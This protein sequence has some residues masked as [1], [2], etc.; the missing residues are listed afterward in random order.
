MTYETIGNITNYDHKEIVVKSEGLIK[1]PNLIMKLYSMLPKDG[2]INIDSA[3]LFVKNKIDE[4]DIKP[5]M[6]G[7][8]FTI[9]SPSILNAS[10]WGAEF[11]ILAKNEVYLF[12]KND[13][14]DAVKLDLNKEGAYCAF[15]SIIFAYEGN[16]WINYLK[17]QKKE[18]DKKNYFNSTLDCIL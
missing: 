6:S 7:M 13:F 11:P 12:E 1:T 16:L 2:S 9:V 10:V 5:H 3:R 18:E 8:G 4:G 14:S 17:S 15:E